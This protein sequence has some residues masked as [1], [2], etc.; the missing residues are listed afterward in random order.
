M[1]AERFEEI[2]IESEP[3]L[4]AWLEAH[5]DREDSVWLVTHKKATPDKYVSTDAI[6]DALVA[7]GWI[8]GRRKKRDDGRTM[9]L[10][11][12]RRV[13]HWAKSYKDRAARLEADGR[14]RAAGRRAVERGKASGL[15]SFMDDVDALIRPQDLEAALA[16]APG[17]RQY[18]AESAPSYQ[19]NV[20][21]WIK[22]AKTPTT[23][24]KRV[25]E[26]VAASAAGARIPQM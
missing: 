25:G 23:R 26:A 3:A 8:D 18:F 1:A 14:M 2:E 5:H 13:E 17:A 24:A 11:G 12:P 7:Y 15:W 16:A 9:Q 20:L 21:C 22:L 19:R 4:W 6:L 10:V